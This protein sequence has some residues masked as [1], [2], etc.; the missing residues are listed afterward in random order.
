MP[1]LWDAVIVGGGHNGLTT[2]A[3]LARTG[4]KVLV[5]E[6]RHEV[7]GACV[8]EETWPG[9]RINTYAYAAGLLRPEI[10]REL[11]LGHYGL[12]TILFDPQ[13][14]QPFSD[15]RALKLWTDT[16]RTTKEIERF[17]GRDAL[18]YPKYLAFWERIVE[19][20]EPV[21]LAPPAPLDQLLK[22]V[23]GEEG[24]RLLRDLILRSAR[25]VLDD[26][27][28][29]DEL[30]GT[31]A[32]NAVIGTFLGPSTPGSAYVLAHH[33]LGNLDGHRE[34]WGFAAGGMGS[35]TQALRRAAEDAGAVIA[36]GVSAKQVLV[37]DGRAV[38][39]ETTIGE[40][41]RSRVVASSVDARQTFLHLTPADALPAEFRE[42]V[43]KIRYRGAQ[44]KFNAALDA[45][46]EFPAAP[47]TPSD[48]H[49][50]A[51]EI[52]P[53]LDYLDRAFDEAKY[54]RFSSHPFLETLF[55]SVRDP[56]VAPPGKHTMTCFVQ[57]APYELR[58]R[59][60]EDAKPS[61]ADTILRTLEERAP[62]VREVVRDFQVITPPDVERT[63]GLTGGS[64]FQGDI[65]PDQILGFR[66]VPGWSGYRTPLPGL[67][68]CGSAAHP[69]GGVLGAPGRNAAKVILADL[70]A[71][72]GARTEGA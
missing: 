65:T 52:S 3:Y 43:R 33:S 18:A 7:G 6:R 21:L 4:A 37:H 16:E 50:G 28:E 69:G 72:G 68:L 29:S 1:D 38:G 22:V 58:G 11:N 17:S 40:H 24:E 57:Y 45:L 19:I 8:T 10:V 25:D 61:V 15:G 66:P 13:M 23:P 60:W 53:S 34:V 39:V 54:G 35:I 9:F 30:K 36:K 2:A 67:Y 12:R 27:F 42:R 63:L 5:L 41:L 56:S 64:I 48:A 44:V 59:S 51:L 55:Q 32:I 70:A 31:L 20:L 49:R 47:G 14:F 26:W 46:P 62:N 71:G